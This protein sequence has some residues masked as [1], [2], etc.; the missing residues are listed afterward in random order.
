MQSATAWNVRQRGA[1]RRVNARVLAAAVMF[2]GGWILS[3]AP[4][5][6]ESL[7]DAFADAYRYN[8]QLD[9]QRAT[10]RATDEE[11]NQAYGTM[12][13]TV[14]LNADVGRQR[15]EVEIPAALARQTTSQNGTTS[16]RGYSIQVVQPLFRGFQTI[17]AVNETEASVRAGRELLRNVEQEVLLNVTQSYGNVVRDQAIVRLRENNLKVLQN[18]LKAT[19][20]RFAVGEVTRTDVAQAQAKV[21]NARS[22]LDLAKANLQTSRSQYQQ[23]VGHAPGTLVEPRSESKLVPRSLEEAIGV[24]SHENPSVVAALYQE[25]AARFDIDKIRGE[26]LPEAQL[27]GTFTERKEPSTTTNEQETASIVGRVR[28]PI[29]EGGIIYSRVRQ[30]K[31]THLAR[32][33]AIEQQRAAAQQQVVAAWSQLT[34]ARA[35]ITSDK[36]QIE[37]NKTALNGVREEEKVGQ[38]T[39]LDV[40][41]AQLELTT[42]EVQFESTKRNLLVGAYSVISAMGR[43]NVAEVGAVGTVYDPVVHLE[44]TSGKWYGLD[45]TRDDGSFEHVRVDQAPHA[46]APKK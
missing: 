30:A 16:P 17:N 34:A 22:E 2:A 9:A 4:A 12:R 14:T 39:V 24:S 41:N 5:H 29:Y 21:A 36:A 37:A 28:V 33:Q 43:L 20:D 27:E 35:Q 7:I 6:A 10:L 13:P 46:R 1:T 42:S 38:R 15:T 19:Q 3:S 44:E 32:L 40:L 23:F 45:I 18:E 31:Q 8:P 11:V 26:L 25:Q